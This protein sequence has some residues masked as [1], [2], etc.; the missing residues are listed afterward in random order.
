VEG[1]YGNDSVKGAGYAELTG[2]AKPLS[3]KI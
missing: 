2:Y 3:G 1:K